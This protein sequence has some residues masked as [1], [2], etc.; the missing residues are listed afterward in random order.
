MDDSEIIHKVDE[1]HLSKKY[2]TI[3]QLLKPYEDKQ[4]VNIEILW[5]LTRAYYDCASG[6]FTIK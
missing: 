2:K 3:F 6:L 1:L 4:E 5:R